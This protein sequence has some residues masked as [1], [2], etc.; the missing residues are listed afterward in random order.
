MVGHGMTTREISQKLC[1][2]IKTI[3]NFRVRI[4]RT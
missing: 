1:R 3:E 4:K 2:S